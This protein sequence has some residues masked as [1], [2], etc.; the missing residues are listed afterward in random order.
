M[1][2]Y[3]NTKRGENPDQRLQRLFDEG[4]VIQMLH[5]GKGVR[6]ITNTPAK[7]EHAIKSGY[8]HVEYVE[9]VVKTPVPRAKSAAAPKAEVEPKPAAKKKTGTRGGEPS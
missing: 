3:R 1:S 6:Y 4:K 8:E 9:E 7:I 5:P 2:R